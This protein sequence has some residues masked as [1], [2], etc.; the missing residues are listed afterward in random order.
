MKNSKEIYQKHIKEFH[1]EYDLSRQLLRSGTSVG[2]NVREANNAE[3]R[4]DF[5]HKLSISLK[6]CS[7]VIYWLELLE[8]TKYLT[9]TQTKKAKSQAYIIARL[10]HSSLK[11]AKSNLHKQK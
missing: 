11:T 8:R 10:L 2:A 5:I 3:S 9:E 6:E 7:E 1:K 4:R